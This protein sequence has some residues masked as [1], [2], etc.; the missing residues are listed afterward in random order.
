MRRALPGIIKQF[1]A[2]VSVAFLVLPAVAQD[3][4]DVPSD[5]VFQ[6]IRLDDA[7]VVAVD[8]AGYAWYYDFTLE[9]WVRGEYE[10]DLEGAEIEEIEGVSGEFT[11]HE[12]R[13][14]VEKTVKPFVNTV[15]IGLDEYVD[16]DVIAYDRVTVKG[17]VKGDVTSINSRVMVT[18]TGRVDGDITAPEIIV[19]D[20][21]IVLGI[22]KEGG[23]ITDGGGPSPDGLIVVLSF[24]FIFLF[25]GFLVVTLMPRQMGNFKA[26][27]TGN[28]TKS[29]LVGLF[30]LLASPVLM[31][32]LAITIVGIVLLPLVPVVY[33]I[34][35]IMGVVT[36]GDSIGKLLMTR[37]LGEKKSE[38]FQSMT[39]VL[40]LMGLWFITAILLSSNGQPAEGFGILFLVISI[41]VSCYPVCAGVGSAL[42]TRFGY[43][44]YAA[45]K[46]PP[47]TGTG[48][49]PVPAPPPIPKAPPEP[50]PS[51]FEDDSDETSL[52]SSS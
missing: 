50:G 32:L 29:F 26:C 6:E 49:A 16:G 8:T 27:M 30:F 35:I 52:S 25:G 36:F 7:G 11:A 23:I 44:S 20:G 42:L 10:P 34:A 18:Q 45:W 3:E 46:R 40:A 9:S 48:P 15:I 43:K 21:G 24:A 12:E 31:A 47:G 37:F 19:K 1:I 4:P 22:E 13:C 51:G 39:G 41:L 5:T 2:L 17:W 14:T 28:R 33:L 38:L